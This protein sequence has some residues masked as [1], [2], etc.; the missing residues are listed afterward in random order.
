MQLEGRPGFLLCRQCPVIAPAL[1]ACSP[2]QVLGLQMTIFSMFFLLAQSASLLTPL[3]SKTSPV[4]SRFL[5]EAFTDGPSVSL[6][7]PLQHPSVQ[8]HRTLNTTQD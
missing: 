4:H 2:L 1:G 7:L 5:W 6:R 3:L 8:S